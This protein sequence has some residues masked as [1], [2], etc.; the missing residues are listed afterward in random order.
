MGANKI[1]IKIESPNGL[2]IAKISW[3]T[4]TDREP[5]EGL[6]TLPLQ[7]NEESAQPRWDLLV[8]PGDAISVSIQGSPGHTGSFR[9]GSGDWQPMIESEGRYSGVYVVQPG[10]VFEDAPVAF[11][12]ERNR[13]VEGKVR[14]PRRV[15][16][17][18]K[19]RVS[20]RN[21]A[22]PIVAEV[23][24]EMTDL[25]YGLGE[26]RLG[27]PILSTVPQGTQLE[28]TGKMGRAWRVRLSDEIEAWVDDRDIQLLPPGTAPARDYLTSFTVS[29]DERNDYISI[30]Y[31]VKVP[32]RILPEVDPNALLID[33]FGVTANTTW[34]TIRQEEAKGIRNVDWE[35]VAK[36]HYRLKV[37]LDY[38][39]LW[40][41]D[42]NVDGGQLHIAIRRPPALAAAPQSPLAGLTVAVEAGHGGPDNIGARGMSGSLEKEVNLGT[43]T[44]LVKLLEKAGA[45]PVM[46]RMGDETISLG[47]RVKRAIEA[48]ADLFISIHANSAGSSGGYLRVK[49]TSTYYKYLPWR[50]LSESIL[51]RLAALGLYNWGNIGSFN[52][53][54]CLTT[55][56][57]S[58]LA[59]L[60]FMSHPGDEELLVDPEFQKQMAEA[61]FLGI[62]DWLKTQR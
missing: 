1:E 47:D 62:E 45:K 40:G 55:Q 28:L 13:E 51:D 56:M 3:V 30:P 9:I 5:R 19:G 52:Y 58:V 44:H 23:S 29:G 16:A 61:I 2:K 14:S 48:N 33:L 59:E 27:G 35:Q 6:S 50:P 25:K 17:E 22:V 43:A 18:S 37:Y 7:F 12:L 39:Q 21:T 54:P 31:S 15:E 53:R 57:P 36:D 24:A 46:V 49:G 32:F 41:Y 38:P 11:R 8:Q 20:V 4:R 26:V 34:I 60:A 42:A 10:D